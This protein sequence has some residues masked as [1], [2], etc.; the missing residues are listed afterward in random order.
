MFRRLPFFLI[1]LVATALSLGGLLD[2]LDLRL[3]DQ[4]FELLRRPA[5]PALVLV[6]I[7]ERSLRLLYVWPWPRSYHAA[8][9]DRLREAGAKTIAID[10]DFSSVS[11]PEADHAF[12][13]ALARADRQVILPVFLQ[14]E[15]GDSS[16]ETLVDTAPIELLAQHVQLGSIVIRPETDGYVRQIEPLARIAN[17]DI[18]SLPVLT[19]D[20]AR[21]STSPYFIDFGIDLA[22]LRRISYVDVIN[23]NFDSDFFRGRNVLVGASAIELGD[24]L[25]VPR[26]VNLPGMHVLALATESITQGRMLMR[27]GPIATAITT[28]L[29]SLVIGPYLVA[30]SWR[31]SLVI[32]AAGSAGAFGFSTFVQAATPLSLDLAAPLLA[33][34]LS[35]AF[36]L[37]HAIERQ[38]QRIFRQKMMAIYRATVMREIVE[39]SFDAILTID[40]RGRVS[41]TNPAAEKLFGVESKASLKRAVDSVLYLPNTDADQKRPFSDLLAEGSDTADLIEGH[42]RRCDGTDVPVEMAVRRVTLSLSRNDT[43]SRGRQRVLHFVTVRDVTIRK[44]AEQ[45][46]ERAL[47]E[48]VASNRAKVEFLATM[49]HELRT[50]LNAI[51]GFSEL[52]KRQMLGPLGNPKYQ[53]YAA[54]IHTSGTRL[55]DVITDILDVARIEAGQIELHESDADIAANVEA[56]LRLAGSRQKPD[57]L[58]IR[59]ALPDSLPALHCDER[60]LKQILY[61]LISNAFKFTPAGG[62]V[63]ITAN[64]EDNGAIAISVAD[65]GIGI[66][67]TEIPN[68][69]KPFY[70]VDSSLAR[71]FEGT[72]LGLALSHELMKLHG[73]E[74][75]VSSVIGQGTDVTCRFPAERRVERSPNAQTSAGGAA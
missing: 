60:L 52:F 67:E 28:L 48:A 25:T 1:F 19:N 6:E 41:L 49:S 30:R 5:S 34:W 23:G 58:D 69:T 57:E 73:G 35:L 24:R 72:G 13:A 62:R 8:L 70:Q 26:Y 55:L 38:A 15:G 18:P 27:S 9:V 39:S 74:L 21:F 46:K 7:D 53:E 14:P 29:V 44:Q 16:L 40:Q 22:T 31:R 56:A 65:T 64:V 66:A 32:V 59:V 3:M 11:T 68:L 61:N 45:A 12:A 75:V 4:R 20:A 50:P 47:A 43:A 51:I 42:A 10:I 37:V 33:F 17:K 36:G 71:R 63:S 54:D 2:R